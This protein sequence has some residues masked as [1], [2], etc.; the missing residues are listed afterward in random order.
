M[1]N[2]TVRQLISVK[3]QIKPSLLLKIIFACWLSVH[4]YTLRFWFKWPFNEDNNACRYT[5]DFTMSP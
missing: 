5:L 4:Y 1:K 2:M 3:K